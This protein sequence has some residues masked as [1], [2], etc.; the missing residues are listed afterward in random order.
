MKVAIIGA[1]IAGLAA[2]RELRSRGGEVVVF[3]K[4]KAVGGRCA[5]RRVEAY[6]FDTGATSIAP[7]GLELE[8]VMTAELDASELVRI[9]APIWTMTFGRTSPGDAAKSATP[10]Y[11]YRSGINRLGKL[12]AEGIEIRRETLVESVAGNQV[13]GEAFDAVI[14]TCPL[15]QAVKLLEGAG[16]PRVLAASRYRPSLS[17]LLGYATDP[18]PLPY[19][20]LIE[21]EQRSPVIWFSVESIKSPGRAPEGHAAIVAQFGGGYSRDHYDD[22]DAEVMREASVAAGRIWGD[23]FANPDVYQVKRWRYAQPESMLSFDALNPPGTRLVLAGDGV[24][25]PRVELAFESGLR[26]ARHVMP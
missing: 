8:R 4:S 17:V 22:S 16:D 5:T 26:A 6:T 13:V 2:A 19:H 12:L 25:G 3:E 23:A 21:P 18:G 9:Q 20:A 7:R 14:L 10:R 11:T 15:P 24:V 1:G